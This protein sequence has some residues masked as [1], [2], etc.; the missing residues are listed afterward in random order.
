MGEKVEITSN[1]YLSLS[2]VNN[3]LGR[4]SDLEFQVYNGLLNNMM[5]ELD[6][7]PKKAPD[8]MIYLKGSFEMVLSRIMKRARS[9]ELDPSLEAY[10][11][12]LWVG[13]DEWVMKHYN[14]SDVL[15]IDMDQ[16]DVV[17]REEDA[18]KLIE[19]V[20]E[21]LKSHRQGE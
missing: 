14:A 17:G 15:I 2:K 5:E 3:D 9:Y 6:E 1:P 4:I 20:E 13:Y 10:Y 18:Q 8:L 19:M 11:Y 12:K 16:F 21:K 7:L